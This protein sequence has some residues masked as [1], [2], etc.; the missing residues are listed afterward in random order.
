MSLEKVFSKKIAND[1]L[2]KII[3]FLKLE[4][5]I[6][7]KHQVSINIAPV[8]KKE[9]KRLNDQ[10]RNKDEVTD[11]L[12]FGYVF[13]QKKLEGD[14]ILCWEIIQ[15]NAKEDGIESNQELSKNLIHG[16]LHLTGQ[17]HSDK[18]LAL[19]NKFLNEDYN[20]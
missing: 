12:S 8:S 16:C 17:E 10:Y 19:Q 1:L 7:D 5:I 9:I 3:D 13:S 20:D 14:L 6:S 2:E 11:I 15:K 4:K 18:M